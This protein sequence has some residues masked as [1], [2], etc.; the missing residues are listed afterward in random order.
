MMIFRKAYQVPVAIRDK[1]KAQ[2]QDGIDK[3]LISPV[4]SS[5]WASPQVTVV[6]QSG[7]VRLC[8]DY[9]VT[10]NQVL[11]GD[12]YPLPSAQD[13]FAQLSGAKYFSNIY[14]TDAFQQLKLSER[15]KAL[16]TLVTDHKPLMM[17][18]GAK[19]GIPTLAADRMQRWSSIL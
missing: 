2:L 13:L 8:G 19:T 6:K 3:G 16:L 15:S 5:E 11:D 10:V 14:L 18:F 7:D 1:V 9:K 4:K 12:Q 17:L